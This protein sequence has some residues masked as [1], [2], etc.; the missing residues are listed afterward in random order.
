MCATLLTD[1][2]CQGAAQAEAH[3]RTHAKRESTRDR[4]HAPKTR[5][6]PPG[7]PGQSFQI[8][9]SRRY[10]RGAPLTC[11]PLVVSSPPASHQGTRVS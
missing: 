5:Q 10:E 4:R 3:A 11:I 9:A 7:P 8:G 6:P 2:I 1:L